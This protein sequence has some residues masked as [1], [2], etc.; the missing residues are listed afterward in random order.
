MLYPIKVTDIELSHPLKDIEELEGYMRLQGLV[1]LHGVPI[2]YIQVPITNGY[3][4]AE[5]IA[6][7]ILDHHNWKIIQ[8]LLQNGL[9]ASS[10]TDRLRLE[11]LYDLPPTNYGGELPLVTVAVCTRDRASDLAL[12]LD[13]IIKLDYPKLDILVIDNAPTS[14]ATKELVSQYPQ[15][16]Y[17]CEPRP[18][19]D[20]ARNRA[21]IEAKGEIIAYT[22]DDVVVDPGWVKALAQVFAENPEVMA[23]TGL[24][25]PYEL[26]TEAQVLFE[27]QGGFGKGFDRKWYRANLHKKLSW[28][29]LATGNYGTGANMAYRRNVFAQVGYFD[30][31]LDVGTVTNGAGD[32]EMFFRVIKE[33]H[34]LVYEP[35]A[36]VRHRH[37]RE[38]EKLKKQLRGNG[39]VI[40]YFVR[41]TKFYPEETFS[42]F[43][44]GLIWLVTYH[45]RRLLLS[46]IYPTLY[47]RDL[48]LAE[49]SG[50]LEGLGT[51]Q[52]SSKNATQIA[53]EHGDLPTIQDYLEKP[54]ASGSTEIEIPS[55]Y[56]SIPMAVRRVELTEPIRPITDLQDYAHVRIFPTWQHSSLGSFDVENLYQPISK[57][58]LCE[59]IASHM[60]VRLLETD[61]EDFNVDISWARATTWIEQHYKPTQLEN[62]STDTRLPDHI[63]VSIVVATYDRPDDL[64]KCLS[65]LISQETSRKV[66]II[67]VD[68]HPASGL[69]PPA[70]KQFSDVILVKESRQGV[71]YA[72]NAGIVESTGNIVV[73]IDDDVTMAPTWLENL[74]SPFARPDVMAVT[75]NVLPRELNTDSQRLFEQY[76]SGGLSRGFNRWEANSFVFEHSWF[77]SVP[78]WEL[79]G[80][81]NAA[82]RAKIFNNPEIGLEDEALGPGMP[83]GVGEDIYAFYKILKAG[84]TIIYQPSAVVWHKHRTTMK[85]L[86]RQLFN[87]S[88]GIISYH[89]TT[90][91]HDGDWRGL[92]AAVFGLPMWQL[93]RIKERFQRRCPH[94]IP[95][96]LLEFWGNLSGPWSLW[97]SRQRVK[98]QGKSTPYVAV[99][100][101]F[102]DKSDEVKI[103]SL[104]GK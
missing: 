30:P 14:T 57:S 102:S 89:L 70:L 8:T 74:I 18:G 95:M 40:A 56:L 29:D 77:Y 99:A 43:Y 52:K 98:R 48:I 15:V 97:I 88:K 80:T 67:V 1:R 64:S 62:L 61:L 94:P 69:T 26:E 82:F 24:V 21:I 83:S 45:L 78:T 85:A 92:I 86:R 50:C 44:L 6:K 79:G 60:G 42:F 53:L 37:R 38:Y 34:T 71:A 27:M 91:L 100:Q 81:A 96:I 101:R 39:G 9:A 25:V 72:R 46:L 5:K 87:Y 51:Y 33:G 2:G 12:C 65:S 32:L 23:V 16:R 3:C 49:L 35:N 22:D 19:L 7:A 75:G 4:R 20:W 68:N 58:R 31:A 103:L 90:F 66:E 17:S 104:K 93:K 36:I 28:W 54:V 10:K 63:S 73:T 13:A 41:S 84:Y 59:L 55:S 76:G 11:N 47:P